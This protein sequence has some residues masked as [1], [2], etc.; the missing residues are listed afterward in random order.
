MRSVHLGPWIGVRPRPR[1]ALGRWTSPAARLQRRGITPRLL[2]SISST[3][4]T[5]AV[6]FCR[7]R[8]FCLRSLF[9]MRTP[10]SVAGPPCPISKP[11]AWC[12]A[13]V[14]R[15][16]RGI[17]ADVELRAGSECPWPA[18]CTILRGPQRW[19]RPHQRAIPLQPRMRRGRSPRQEREA[20]PPQGR[21]SHPQ[22]H[23]SSARLSASIEVALHG[24]V[25]CSVLEALF[26]GLGASRGAPPE[27]RPPASRA[28][29]VLQ[30]KRWPQISSSSRMPSPSSSASSMLS[31]PSLSWS[32]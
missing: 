16:R 31:V 14:S 19:R 4:P 20:R 29:A 27:A 8:I 15:R 10:S 22:C 17:N 30:A 2:K 32:N 1:L 25:G 7:S 13:A 11:W 28:G 21:T 26:R 6:F 12:C 3:K 5:A 24:M 18:R 23:R 9:S